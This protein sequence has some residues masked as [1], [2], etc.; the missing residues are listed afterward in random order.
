MTS[1]L[2]TV[3]ICTN[4]CGRDCGR[5]PYDPQRSGLLHYKLLLAKGASTGIVERV[6]LGE[7]GRG[8]GQRVVGVEVAEDGL[9]GEEVILLAV[10]LLL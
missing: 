3:A 6:K 8:W 1:E 7:L 4:L 2:Y 10:E 9:R 5:W